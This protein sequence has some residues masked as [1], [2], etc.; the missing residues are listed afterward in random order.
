MT[1]EEGATGATP[2]SLPP[3][4]DT[5]VAD[6]LLH[7][8][9][10]RR[11]APTTVRGYVTDVTSM[12]DHLVR[13]RG[14]TDTTLTDLDLAVLRSWLARRRTS[15]AARTSLARLVSSARAFC[16]WAVR[17]GRLQTDP[18]ARL[19]A[20]RAPRT[21]PAVLTQDQARRMLD[22]PLFAAVDSAAGGAGSPAAAEQPLTGTTAAATSASRTSASGPTGTAVSPT[23]RP[24]TGST[25]GAAR[26]ER[27]DAGQP[28][29]DALGLAIPPTVEGADAGEPMTSRPTPS[30]SDPVDEA[31]RARDRA[32][33]ELLYATAVR[34]S[35]LV[36]L[37]LADVDH[38]RRTLRVLGKGNKQRTVP[39][40]APA[41]QALQE[42]LRHRSA[43]V[44][45]GTVLALFL[46]RRGRRLDPR[47][48]RT[49]VHQATRA[50][51]GAPELAPHGLRHSAATHLLDGGADLRVVQEM[52]GHS[53]A[54][55]TQ[56]YTHVSAERLRSVY[57][58][59]HPRA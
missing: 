19:L 30:D 22:A 6:F 16:R 34:V 7:L 15:G 1:A 25:A 35:E 55:T 24:V 12:L 49:L 37:D 9:A 56:I 32:V 54:A 50:V 5:A 23:E 2:S 18:S 46:G 27:A 13:Y 36:G 42:Y 10:E 20:P 41:A 8:Q 44:V 14:S 51:D 40:G 39:F 26:T 58:Q 48:V 45:D 47:A 33:L 17:T 21:L 11:L 53:S 59:A 4:L 57:Q 28:T 52:L 43:L 31:V 3:A 38:H 29:A